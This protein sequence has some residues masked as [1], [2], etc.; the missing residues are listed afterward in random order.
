MGKCVVARCRRTPHP[1]S[2]APS[3]LTFYT[4]NKLPESR[5]SLFPGSLR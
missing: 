3:G 1:Q 2:I 4:G 5:N